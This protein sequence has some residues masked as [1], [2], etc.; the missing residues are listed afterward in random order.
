MAN[1]LNTPLSRRQ[2]LRNGILTAAGAG[3]LGSGT[4]WARSD[5]VP[6]VVIGSGFGGAVAA[7]RLGQAGIDTVVL[8]RGRRWPIRRDGNTFATF[9]QPDGRAHWL[10]ERTAEGILGLPFLEKPIERYVGVLEVVV[11]NG[12]Y[13]GAGAGV[14][15]GSL[16][17]NAL[18][19][20]PRRE[21]LGRILPRGIDLD[22]MEDIYYPRVRQMI[23]AGPIPDDVLATAYYR[24]S[25]VSLDQAHTAGFPTRVVDLAVDWDIVRD[26]IAGRRVPSAIAGQAWYGLNSG[27]KRSLDHNYLAAAEA[28][29]HVE[30]LPLHS[31]VTIER[32][33]G[34]R[35]AVTAV[36][37]AD[38]GEVVGEQRLVCKYLFLAAGS[39][40]TTSLLV[41]AR[42][43]GALPAL[44]D[45]VGRHWAANGDIPVTRGALPFTNAGTGGPGGHFIMEDLDNPFGPTSLVE[46]VFPPHI[47]A[48][49]TASG[50]PASFAL[51]ASLGVPPAIG[52]FAYDGVNDAVTLTWPSGDPQLAHFFA[53][54]QHTASG[55]DRSNGSLTLGLNPFVSAHPLGGAV[56]GKACDLDGRVKR[57]PG[58][59]VV[60]GALIEG[61]TGLA[62]PAFTIAALA[63]RCLDRILWRDSPS[64][65][66]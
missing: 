2:L 13:I 52:S 45:H 24:S 28:T 26:E 49:L 47:V 42:A 46:L 33:R 25:R 41:R 27:A 7:L 64:N 51:Y 10:R 44:N 15:G 62:N 61:H 8:E 53:A 60:D 20:K 11:G 54:A 43:T 4:A 48:A 17:Y 5:F 21:L 50:A 37:L 65:R 19:V 40:G 22:E 6:A 31:V 18:M 35:Y 63:E 1:P 29:G 9:E 66:P 58:L 39:I 16:V 32:G 56:L 3:L 59:Y 55:L 36:R 38:N 30:V 14:G 23:G 34:G 57:H 12:I